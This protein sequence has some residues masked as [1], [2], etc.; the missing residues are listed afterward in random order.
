LPQTEY[1][2]L[3]ILNGGSKSE[4]AM[5]STFSFTPIPHRA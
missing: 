1:V 2:G 4:S 3:G 5:F